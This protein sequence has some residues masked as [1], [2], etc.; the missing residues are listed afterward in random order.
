MLWSH[1]TRPYQF[2]INTVHK[3][4]SH[5]FNIYWILTPSMSRSFRFLFLGVFLPN[6]FINLSPIPW[7]PLFPL[8]W[9]LYVLINPITNLLFFS[10][11]RKKEKCGIIQLL[12]IFQ[13]LWLLLFSYVLSASSERRRNKIIPRDC[14]S[15]ES[16]L[17]QRQLLSY[18]RSDFI[19][20][21]TDSLPLC[22]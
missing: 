12:M 18:T 2:Q 10:H 3:F 11:G 9:F 21:K 20:P 22:G 16:L 13:D 6:P 15:K 17:F 7:V 5:F 8:L 4:P 19:A 14:H 1:S